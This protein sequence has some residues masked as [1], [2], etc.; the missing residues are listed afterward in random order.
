MTDTQSS[1]G[2]RT[3][4]ASPRHPVLMRND[5]VEITVTIMVTDVNEPPDDE[6]GRPQ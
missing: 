4:R 2:P 1:S 5:S 3:R 6:P